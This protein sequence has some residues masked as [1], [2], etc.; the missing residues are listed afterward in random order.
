MGEFQA[1]L[2]K[3]SSKV[4]DSEIDMIFK[5]IDLDNTGLISYSEFLSATL[6]TTHKLT[7]D[8]LLQAFNDLDPDHS[9]TI[10]TS[11]L[12]GLLEG[13]ADDV[14]ITKILDQVDKD[15]DHRI[16]REEF[17]SL[18]QQNSESMNIQE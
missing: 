12:K 9:G 11:E 1:A 3:S 2:K 5:S 10:E 7:E 13:F 4:A 6:S 14:E 17:L 8:R 15:G 18:C 16:S